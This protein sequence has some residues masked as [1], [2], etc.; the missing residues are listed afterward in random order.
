M[1]RVPRQ[2]HARGRRRDCG[3]SGDGRGVHVARR[4]P[5][6][7]VAYGT[8]RAGI[9]AEHEI[10]G[11]VIR[12]SGQLEQAREWQPAFRQRP[13]AGRAIGSGEVLG[14]FV[15]V[16][17]QAIADLG[18]P[19]DLHSVRARHDVAALAR[20]RLVPHGADVRRMI[21]IEQ[22]RA[23]RR[24]RPVHQLLIPSVMTAR[25][26]R[27]GRE[28]GGAVTLHGVT[29][30]A[31]REETRVLP[32]LKRIHALRFEGAPG[33][34]DAEGGEQGQRRGSHRLALRARRPGSSPNSTRT[35][36]QARRWFQSGESRRVEPCR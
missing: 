14:R 16:T 10:L 22:R 32:V 19:C 18:S 3:D 33:Q 15:R 27:R 7:R 26:L 1:R 13:M 12:R 30:G 24:R 5:F 8:A 4:A 21:V 34:G 29:A 35:A 6:A 2:L 9:V 11:G 36:S 28:V 20:R 23:G 17:G 25:T 31:Q